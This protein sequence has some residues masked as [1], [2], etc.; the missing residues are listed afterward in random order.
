M[1]VGDILFACPLSSP[2]LSFYGLWWS[3]QVLWSL[4]LTQ[5]WEKVLKYLFLQILEKNE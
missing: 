1:A 5:I 2:K 4:K 3:I